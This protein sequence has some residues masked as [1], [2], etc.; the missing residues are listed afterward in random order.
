[1]F[2]FLPTAKPQVIEWSFSSSTSAAAACSCGILQSCQPSKIFTRGPFILTINL[3]P[4]WWTPCPWWTHTRGRPESHG[5]PQTHG[6]TYTHGRR[7][8]SPSIMQLSFAC[9]F[10]RR[11]TIEPFPLLL[12][13]IPR[14]VGIF[15]PTRGGLAAPE[16]KREM[17]L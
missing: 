5:G 16:L 2:P 14:Q 7:S 9:S 3:I 1:M 10:C 12:W 17:L 8:K 11:S 15:F 6:G 13:F 4:I